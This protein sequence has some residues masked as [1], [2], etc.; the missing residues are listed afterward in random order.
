MGEH[1][2]VVMHDSSTSLRLS[3]PLMSLAWAVCDPTSRPYVAG[4][5]GRRELHVLS[6]A[7]LR[8]RAQRVP[9]SFETLARTPASLYVRRVILDC[10]RDVAN[11]R[12]PTRGVIDL[13]WSWLLDGASRWLSGESVYTRALIGRRIREGSRP[14]FPPSARDA[15]LLGA[16]LIDMLAKQ[17]GEDAV[18][19]LAGRLHP[20]G[21]RAALSK[22]FSG[23]SLA[24]VETDW[25][26]EL[27]RLADGG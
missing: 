3:N 4:W 16:S 1:L 10:N 13:R 7:A 21:P 14:Q 9:G 27:R 22:A 8:Q 6:G 20:H 5:S 23:R 11:S 26:F 24:T 19:E 15:P 2:T 18:A 25:R 12:I 17:R